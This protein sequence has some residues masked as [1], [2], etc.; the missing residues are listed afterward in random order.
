MI[1]VNCPACSFGKHEDHVEW[2]RTPVQ[3]LIDGVR[4][5]CTGA[6]VER[7]RR[8]FL[9]LDPQSGRE[10]LSLVNA[11][12]EGEETVKSIAMQVVNQMLHSPEYGTMP[13]VRMRTRQHWANVMA[14]ALAPFGVVEIDQVITS[15]EE[16]DRPGS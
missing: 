16:R 14:V 10:H 12:V 8:P 1:T 7:A 2:L 11:K 15:P 6:C 13:G 5:D 9:S 3:G 4:C